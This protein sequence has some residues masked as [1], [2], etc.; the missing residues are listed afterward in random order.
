M[1]AAVLRTVLWIDRHSFCQPM[2]CNAHP[3]NP[4]RMETPA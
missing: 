2:A 3:F 4:T 1:T